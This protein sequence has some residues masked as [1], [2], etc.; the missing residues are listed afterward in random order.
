MSGGII[1]ISSFIAA[2]KQI[3]KGFG[4]LLLSTLLP[5]SVSKI[6]YGNT[7]P[8][9]P[10]G[11][12]PVAIFYCAE[13]C[14]FQELVSAPIGPLSLQALAAHTLLQTTDRDFQAAHILGF[15]DAQSH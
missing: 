13:L 10:L 11:P 1:S 7:P 4:I 3:G 6:P 15:I 9:R 14:F 12:D 8:S 2:A 5:Y